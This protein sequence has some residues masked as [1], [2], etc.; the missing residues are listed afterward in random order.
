MLWLWK[1]EPVLSLFVLVL[2]FSC[3]WYFGFSDDHREI[4]R[5]ERQHMVAF[6]WGFAMSAMVGWAFLD[7]YK[8]LHK[9][10]LKKIAEC[11]GLIK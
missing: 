3:G 2:A 8:D 11:A 1:V 9:Y 4:E 10:E 6:M 7:V 5:L